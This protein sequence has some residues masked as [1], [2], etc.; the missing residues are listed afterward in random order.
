[1]T[2]STANNGFTQEKI[3]LSDIPLKRMSLS[4]LRYWNDS[5]LYGDIYH[6]RPQKTIV[7][8]VM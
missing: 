4:L 8:A 7:V 1:M 3:W 5:L 2:G 6:K